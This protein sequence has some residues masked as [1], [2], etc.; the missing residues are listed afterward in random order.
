MKGLV[1]DMLYLA[2]NDDRMHQRDASLISISDVVTG[3]LLRFET[4][5]FER[6]VQL[7]SEVQ[8]DLNVFGNVQALDRLTAILLDNAVK[9]AGSSG[10]VCL[11]LQGESE[12]ILLTVRNT[13]EGIPPAHL[14]HIFERFYRADTSR[15]R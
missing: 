14:E 2:K 1:D 8:P 6:A 12:R 5:A 9:Y 15:S 13:G 11:T 3:C 7:D 10:H 4:V